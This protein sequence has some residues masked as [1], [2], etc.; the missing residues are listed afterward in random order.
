[1]RTTISKTFSFEAAHTLAWHEGKC[2][3]LH[4]HSY[5]CVV[6]IT[7]KPDDR[8]II[9]DFDALTPLIED[10]VIEHYDHRLLNDFLE[11]P[12]A[13]RIAADIFSRLSEAWSAHR[14]VGT[15]SAVTVWETADNSA[16]V[17]A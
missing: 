6:E 4:G 17:R 1:M 16:T 9:V 12:T 14:L 7:G 10:A 15:I 3:R 5:R 13:E 8:G 11:N 2:S